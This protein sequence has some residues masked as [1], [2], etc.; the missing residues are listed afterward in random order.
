M[1]NQD[2]QEELLHL[3]S[4]LSLIQD[5]IRLYEA[6]EQA[7]RKEVTALF[8]AVR[9]GEGDSY[10]QLVASQNILE[11][12]QN[13]LRKNKA[14]LDQP[15]FG[16]IVYDDLTYDAS[17]CCYIG[18]N[19][20]SRNQTD[21]VVVDWRAPVSN[22]YYENSLGLGRYA[23]PG[24]EDVEID[25]HQKRTYDISAGT[26]HGYYDDDIAANDDLLVKY[27]SQNKE[28]VL[29]DIIATIQKEQNTI[30][31]DLPNKNI[32]VQGVAGSGKTTVALH[33]ISYL[34]YNYE[35]LYK[36]AEF[37]I[38]GSSDMLLHYIRS[39]L[40]E[41]D[42]HHIHEM[43]MDEVFPYLMG[44]AWKKQYQI[45]PDYP[46]AVVKSHL[47]FILALDAFLERLVEEALHLSDIKD[48]DLGV[49]LSLDSMLETRNY[50]QDDS[51][52]QFEKHLNERILSRLKFLCT[53][54]SSDF[55]KTKRQA[56][57]KY[58]DSSVNKWTVPG[59]YLAFLAEL[60]EQ[61]PSLDFSATKTGVAKGKV[62]VYDAAAFGLIYR[63]IFQKQD[64][65]VFSQIFIDEA[66]DFG[67]TV[68]YAL[69]HILHDCYFTI[70]GDV[71]QNI[72][73]E[74]GMNDWD[75]LKKAMFDSSKDSF[76]LL[77]KS[78]RNTIEIS[79]FAGQVLQKASQGGYQIDPVIRH[80]KP[81]SI[82][83]VESEQLLNQ[84]KETLQSVR[85]KDFE[86]I[87]VICRTPEEANEL[88]TE[89]EIP[90]VEKDNS[91]HN[92]IMIL[93]VSLTKGLEFDCVILWK[94][95]EDHYL[96]HPKDAKLLYVAITR[97]L[98]E[99]YLLT[100]RPLTA[101][102]PASVETGTVID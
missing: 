80:G 29:G 51:L 7:S 4:C 1:M 14:A 96:D 89:L 81:V 87:A 46:E 90:L 95:D 32:I 92:G 72:R 59:L 17:E 42:V 53:E 44:K 26:L 47:P 94:P 99:L 57:R 21:V 43:R 22:V 45:V 100:D 37:C 11:H 50:H 68:Y 30:I 35:D 39:G 6:R 76:Y 67:E 23:V 97:A 54:R 12:V 70:M 5:N 34:L 3:E 88:K 82:T 8:Q 10:G 98:H 55:K 40:P 101:L 71:S 58:F 84:L 16:R 19:G 66:Q 62:D 28:A 65:D 15:Y 69:K 56:F 24:S 31:R 63:R 93:P 2:Y 64:Q 102:L 77:L 61:D 41:L 73:Y 38:I 83:H 79:N 86:T 25:L 74:T 33:R 48:P 78:Y 85:E 9:K 27:L 60:E 13:T 20:I 49:V 91:F 18:K 36:P 52:Y 75:Q